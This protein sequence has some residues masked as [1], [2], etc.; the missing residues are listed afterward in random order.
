[1]SKKSAFAAVSP[2]CTRRI[3]IEVEA[4]GKSGPCWR[5]KAK[6][7][8]E[9]NV[10][11]RF[12][13]FLKLK[14]WEIWSEARREGETIANTVEG[15]ASE[16]LGDSATRQSR[17]GAIS[18]RAP[19]PVPRLSDF[20]IAFIARRLHLSLQELRHSGRCCETLLSL[21]WRRVRRKLLSKIH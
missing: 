21:F 1:M 12:A 3:Q 13:F 15:F 7:R 16:T 18:A 6:E 11:S 19:L 20:I 4:R 9:V 17:S 5:R 14:L 8:S 10:F 2:L